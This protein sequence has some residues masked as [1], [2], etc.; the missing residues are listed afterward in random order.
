MKVLQI[1]TVFGF[2]STGKLCAGIADYLNNNGDEGYVA[3][4]YGL[5][6]DKGYKISTTFD[7]R[8]HSLLSRIFGLQAYYSKKQTRK[9]LRYIDGINP[10]VVHLGNLHSNFINLKMILS[11]LSQKDIP[12][13]F[14]QHDCWGFTGKCGH[15]TVDNCYKWKTGCGKCP[16][17]KKD[18][19]SW[20][21]DR[22]AK[23]Y[24][25]KKEW[26]GSI[27]RLAVVGVSD[28]I[29][30]EAKLSLLSSATIFRRIYNWIDLDIF[31]PVNTDTLRKRL[32]LQDAFVILG[33]ASCWT[34]AKGLSSFIELAKALP[35]GMRIIMVGRMKP[36][37]ELPNAI[38]HIKETH[39]VQEMVEYYSMADVFVHLS[40]EE[41]FGMVTAEALAC[42]TPAIVINSTANPELVG[43]GCGYISNTSNADEIMKYVQNI[44]EAGKS[45]FS[46]NCRDYSTRNFNMNDRVQDY[47]NVY[48]EI[49][50]N[51]V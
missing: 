14:T 41:S 44:R 18:N 21:F 17:L 49:S 12:T 37:V 2:R 39:D 27:P 48:K 10:D 47:I 19:K 4:S 11:Y 5:P 29:T 30:N 34:D 6:Y 32:G 33:V 26:F 13:V 23:M 31:K 25:D 16:R 1:S 7:V 24:K 38:I 42:G 35:D 28:W 40:P 36:N 8:L 45:S 22:T 20:F 51:T 15:F 3:Y 50:S 9:L 46:K 43:D